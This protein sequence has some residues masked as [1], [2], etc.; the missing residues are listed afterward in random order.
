[1]VFTPYTPIQK[2]ARM[3]IHQSGPP[4]TQETMK[5]L[6]KLLVSQVGGRLKDYHEHEFDK[7]LNSVIIA[8]RFPKNHPLYVDERFPE[9]KRLFQDT[10]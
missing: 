3:M 5:V 10:R 4:V 1:M 6:K 7:M 9:E 2:G 8:Q